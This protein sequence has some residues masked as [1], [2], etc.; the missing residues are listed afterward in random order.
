MRPKYISN[1]PKVTQVA[2]NRSRIQTLAVWSQSPSSVTINSACMSVYVCMC[3]HTHSHA[4]P[5]KG[6][7]VITGETTFVILLAKVLVLK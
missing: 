2:N 3:T 7:I 1:L 6:N 4:H 5:F